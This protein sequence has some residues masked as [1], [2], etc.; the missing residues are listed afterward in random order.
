[1][2]P[3]VAAGSAAMF[4]QVAT[5]ETDAE[6]TVIYTATGNESE[7]DLGSIANEDHRDERGEQGNMCSP[8]LPDSPR[9]SRIG[10]IA[11]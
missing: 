5:R 10:K 8:G 1:M 3:V 9:P 6:S 4:E 7:L 11:W 2:Q